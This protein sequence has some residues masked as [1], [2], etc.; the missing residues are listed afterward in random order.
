MRRV[1]SLVPVTASLRPLLVELLRRGDLPP[2]P[3]SDA[4]LPDAPAQVL[5]SQCRRIHAQQHNGRL[6]TVPVLRPAN[7]V[8][9]LP[10]PGTGTGRDAPL[11]DIQARTRRGRRRGRGWWCDCKGCELG[12]GLEAG[13][14]QV[15]GRRRLPQAA[16]G[17]QAVARQAVQAHE[18]V[19]VGGRG[20]GR[21]EGDVVPAEGLEGGGVALLLDCGGVSGRPSCALLSEGQRRTFLDDAVPAGQVT[22]RDAVEVAGIEVGAQAVDREHDARVC[23]GGDG[24]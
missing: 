21:G 14:A 3:P 11:L 12:G 9:E 10:R 16:L 13:R 4:I 15:R 18:A 8:G 23:F 17:A 1:P 2:A 24:G 6:V 22:R 20:G 5:G 7:E 19:A